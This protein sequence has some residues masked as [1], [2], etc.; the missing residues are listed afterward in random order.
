MTNELKTWADLAQKYDLVLFN[1]CVSLGNSE[2]LDEYFEEV[3]FNEEEEKDVYQWYAIDIN[4]FGKEYLNK[5]YN[6]D[7]FY[8]EVLDLYILPVYHF[9]T[10]WEGVRL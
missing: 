6:L 7:I 9:G 4:E 8:S 1:N 5:T 2:V 10:P 3:G